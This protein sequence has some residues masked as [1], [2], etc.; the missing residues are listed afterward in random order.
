MNM[1]V[2]CMMDDDGECLAIHAIIF[3]GK[4]TG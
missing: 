3:L 4:L 2:V 1:F